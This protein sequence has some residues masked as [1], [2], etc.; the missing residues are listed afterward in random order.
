[1]DATYQFVGVKLVLALRQFRGY[2]KNEVL[3]LY[4]QIRHQAPI[5]LLSE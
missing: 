4:L 5:V 1:M 3:Q 2:E